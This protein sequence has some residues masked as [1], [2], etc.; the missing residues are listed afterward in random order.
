MS[1]SRT[2][3]PSQLRCGTHGKGLGGVAMFLML[4]L[5]WPSPAASDGPAA[6]VSLDRGATGEAGLLL[7][8]ND[9][10]TFSNE[11]VRILQENCQQCHQPGGI[12]PMVLETYAQTR[13]WAPMIKE[14][15]SRRMMPPWHLDHTIGIQ[16]YKNDFSLSDEDIRTLVAWVDAGAPEGNP[17]HLP[18]PVRWPNWTEWELEASLGPPDMV[19]ETGPI[20]VRAE[21]GDFWPD[22]NVP[23]PALDEPRFLKAAEIRNSELGRSALHHNNVSLRLENGPSGRVVGAGAGKR[24]DFFGDDTGIRFETG[25]GVVNF[26]AHYFPI[27]EEFTDNIEV[28][29]WF[30]PKD[31]PPATEASV[32][33]HH[34]IDQYDPGQARARDILIPPHGTQTMYR[35]W[36]LDEPVM[37]NSFRGHMHLHGIAMS[38]EVIWPGRVPDYFGPGAN[39]RDVIASINN[40]DHNWQTSFVFEDDARP[41]LPRGTA[42]VMRTHFDNTAENPLSI[43]PDQWVVFGGRSVDAMSH[44]H[45]SVSYLDDDQYE[46][47]LAERKLRLDER[48][49]RNGSVGTAL[50]S[51]HPDERVPFL[52]DEVDVQADR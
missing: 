25:P 38:I 15:V 45:V 44:F 32:E 4:L 5:G 19:F 42:I 10:P 9:P 17:D 23:W 39:R 41:I 11:V 8:D 36:V 13:P 18:P 40:Y 3:L 48:K 51:I 26:G 43:D 7:Q 31:D 14:S 46:T 50:L 27:G 21:G 28:A 47:M 34:L 29:F 30:H 35:T 2:E 24:W 49:K 12:G 52:A 6:H 22:V 1:R 37:L 33:I 16:E 20:E